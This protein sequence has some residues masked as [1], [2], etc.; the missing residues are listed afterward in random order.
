MEKLIK[1][2]NKTKQNLI[3]KA[4]KKGL[5]EN[6]GRKEVHKLEDKYIDSSIYT[7]E[8]NKKRQLVNCFS[9]W[10]SNYSG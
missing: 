9:D 6:F 3:E 1:E 2:I 8:M 4:S 5:Y 7:D 10:C